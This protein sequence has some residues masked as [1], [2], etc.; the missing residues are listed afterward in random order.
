MAGE[1]R[2]PEERDEWEMLGGGGGLTV[3]RTGDT[4]HFLDAR[5]HAEEDEGLVFSLG[6]ESAKELAEWLL[7]RIR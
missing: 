5:L 2:G 7:R 1:E 4:F 6:P 3:Y